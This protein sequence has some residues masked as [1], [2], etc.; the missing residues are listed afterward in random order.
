MGSNMS[1]KNRGQSQMVW[2]YLAHG[3]N[4]LGP[5]VC[6]AIE[7]SLLQAILQFYSHYC[8]SGEFLCDPYLT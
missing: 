1:S 6:Y 8:L 3:G 2:H 5:Q 4:G 7:N